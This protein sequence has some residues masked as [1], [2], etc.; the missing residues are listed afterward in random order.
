MSEV[1]RGDSLWSVRNITILLILGA[2]LTTVMVSSSSDID[3]EY[4][5]EEDDDEEDQENDGKAYA[6]DQA[7]VCHTQCVNAGFEEDSQQYWMCIGRCLG[8]N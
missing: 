3:Y 7:K 5:D 4:D 8:G 1:I 6:W 2:F